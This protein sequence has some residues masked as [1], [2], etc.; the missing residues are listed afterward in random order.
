M[1]FMTIFEGG[2]F[3]GWSKNPEMRI[4][5]TS[6]VGGETRGDRDRWDGH[7]GGTVVGTG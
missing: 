2:Q 4:S 5:E 7:L 6:T 3:R 1:L